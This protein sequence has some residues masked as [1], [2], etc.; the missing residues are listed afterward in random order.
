[1]AQVEAAHHPITENGRQ[2]EGA[3]MHA[4]HAN[5]CHFSSDPD[6]CAT[7]GIVV[8]LAL[9][10]GLPFVWILWFFATEVIPEAIKEEI[11]NYRKQYMSPTVKE[12][13][14]RTRL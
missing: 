5:M 10:F 4:S 11:R 2:K 3:D 8:Y 9:F 14:E 12:E 1:M 13:G 6:G 7:V